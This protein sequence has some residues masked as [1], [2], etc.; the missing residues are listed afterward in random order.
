LAAAR[1]QSVTEFVEWLMG[2]HKCDCGAKYKVTVTDTPAKSMTCEKCG[3]M[4]DHPADKSR[5]AYER[6]PG[7]NDPPKVGGAQ[8]RSPKCAACGSTMKLTTI[9]PSDTGRDLRTF[10][11]PHCA[12]IQRYIIE[13][14]VTEAL[15][16]SEIARNVMH[17]REECLIQ[18]SACRDKAQA[19][20]AS[21][22]YWI[23]RAIVWH[24]RAVQ[25]SG[26]K[27]VT[28]EVHNGRMI[29]KT[30]K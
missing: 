5:L 11:C 29:S 28:Y 4:M 13:S 8:N 12:T 2:T 15:I 20:P 1:N 3:I 19:D 27:A 16:K 30:T 24:R 6:M 25:A 21:A 7:R 14:S 18:A 17:Q 10:T 9:E 26:G 22:K 23:D